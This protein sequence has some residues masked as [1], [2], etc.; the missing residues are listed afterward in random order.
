MKEI[1]IHG[2]GGQGCVEAANML[3]CAAAERGYK[4]LAFA[5]FGPERRGAPV[6]AYV[7][8][9]R[10]NTPS[11]VKITEPD[12][13][14]IFDTK[15]ANATQG[16]KPDG[17]IIINDDNIVELYKKFRDRDFGVAA[18][19]ANKIA[20]EKS[21]PI[22]TAMVGAAGKFLGLPLESIL[23]GVKQRIE[24]IAPDKVNKN[25][26]TA[27]DGY[28]SAIAVREASKNKK[29]ATLEKPMGVYREINPTP[30]I[31]VSRINNM[32]Y[33]KTGDWRTRG[34]PIYIENIAPCSNACPAGEEIRE[35]LGFTKENFFIAAWTKIIEKNPFPATCGRVCHHPCE[36]EC[37]MTK[38]WNSP[39][40]IN[41]LEK[42][43]GDLGLSSSCDIYPDKYPK[44]N[45]KVAIIGG[46]PAGLSCAYHLAKMGYL[47]TIF[48]ASP[49]LGGMLGLA[50][51]EFRLPKEIV[52]REIRNILR[53]DRIKVKM[54]APILTQ[55][56]FYDIHTNFKAICVA[57]GSHK[58][59]SLD[60]PG[61]SAINPASDKTNPRVWYGLEFLK[62]IR[63]HKPPDFKNKTVIVIG[64]GN[65][66]IDAARSALK[67]CEAEKVII[68]YRRTQENMPAIKSEIKE[69]LKEGIEIKE[70]LSPLE[71]I[72]SVA[73]KTKQIVFQKMKE[74]KEKDSSKRNKVAPLENQTESLKTDI[75]IIAAGED[76]TY[77]CFLPEEIIKAPKE[78]QEKIDGV[79]FCGD[80]ETGPSFVSEAIGSGRKTAEKIDAYINGKDI[81]TE[82]PKIIAGVESLNPFYLKLFRPDLPECVKKSREIYPW[83]KLARPT[84]QTIIKESERCLS[85]GK[86]DMCDNC[87]NFCPELCV[88]KQTS[89]QKLY[90]DGTPQN[91]GNKYDINYDYCKG[92]GICEEECPR[93]VIKFA[94]EEK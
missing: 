47:I 63:L 71:I 53:T 89:A 87:Y 67:V 16:L 35:W 79:F 77:P 75:V 88:S 69:S 64:G 92:C 23:L 43:L 40:E 52:D 12:M 33:N 28:R 4:V 83:L 58:T 21:T 25:A 93:S 41:C 48:E 68:A 37:N 78:K 19:N 32:L 90:D 44:R 24:K 55:K 20:K 65:T 36:T 8:I 91:Y 57:I 66:A 51:P 60:I 5:Q 1:R 13:V 39:I 3:A 38:L 22:N 9:D 17:W 31:S 2:R 11:R 85:C 42:L 18:I 49:V 70:L 59:K 30:Q 62:T 29:M 10:E 46:G 50:I 86:C 73:N 7:K 80:A 84:T 56:D 72:H 14:I 54:S 15:L 82:K 74:I 94:E 61:E 6:E 26:E 76:K 34:K 45:E 27:T 81:K